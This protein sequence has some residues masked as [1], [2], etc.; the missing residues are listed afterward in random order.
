MEKLLMRIFVSIFLISY[1]FSLPA[2]GFVDKKDTLSP[3]LLSKT[4]DYSDIQGNIVMLVSD[5]KNNNF[6]DFYVKFRDT[7]HITSLIGEMSSAEFFKQMREKGRVTLPIDI[8]RLGNLDEEGV[9]YLLRN[10][11]ENYRLVQ[12]TVDAIKDIKPRTLSAS[13]LAE[14]A[15]R[16]GWQDW[17][18][19]YCS[20][21]VLAKIK[22]IVEMEANGPDSREIRYIINEEINKMEDRNKLSEVIDKQ[23]ISSSSMEYRREIPNDSDSRSGIKW[24]TNT[25][26]KI[27]AEKITHKLGFG[28][29]RTDDKYPFL[30]GDNSYT[31]GFCLRHTRLKTIGPLVFITIDDVNVSDLKKVQE[32][33]T[34]IKDKLGDIYLQNAEN[35]FIINQDCKVFLPSALDEYQSATVASMLVHANLLKHATVFDFGSGNGLLSMIAL[36][37]GAGRVVLVEN[38]KKYHRQAYLFLKANG[39]GEQDVN[40]G[41]VV[42]LH[43]DLRNDSIKNLLPKYNLKNKSVV[44]IANIGPQHI[45][46]DTNKLVVDLVRQW[47]NLGL[48]INGGYY[49]GQD[50]HENELSRVINNLEGDGFSVT[51]IT[52]YYAKAMSAKRV[53]PNSIGEQENDIIARIH[54]A[55]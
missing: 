47:P 50:N 9:I 41:K 25:E 51:Q 20:S 35:I 7:F 24:L 4:R 12:Y 11:S 46:G 5:A 49:A 1:I 44:A 40:N 14:I 19:D 43:E 37:L 3:P 52:S 32:G 30:V 38:D 26:V 45:Y 8:S 15:L 13:L 17:F 21:E 2:Y 10:F 6:S 16:Y 55:V 22:D 31:R 34:Y 23:I 48:F 54:M 36:R 33:I 27:L 29:F 42:Y 28:E 18:K 39:F 53:L